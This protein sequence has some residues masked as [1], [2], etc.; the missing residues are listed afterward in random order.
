MASLGLGF[1][2]FWSIVKQGGVFE[3]PPLDVAQRTG[4]GAEKRAGS[5]CSGK[6]TKEFIALAGFARTNKV[7]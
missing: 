7:T 3:D 2:Y 1:L 6:S 5:F 4:K